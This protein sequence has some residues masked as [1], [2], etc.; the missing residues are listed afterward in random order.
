MRP[1][2]EDD[3]TPEEEVLAVALELASGSWKIAFQ[4]GKHAKPAVLT[5]SADQASVR[6]QEVERE[7]AKIRRK[8]HVSAGARTVVLYEAGQDGFWIQ[9]ALK[10]RGIKTLICDPG[11]I[12]MPRKQRRA[13][14]D[15]LAAIKLVSCLRG[16]LRGE[17]DRMHLIRVPEE[18]DEA[19]R[20]LSRERGELV[21]E[22]MQH[23]DRIRKLLR[24]LGGWYSV[25]GD[26]GNQLRQ[27]QIR[28]HDGTSLPVELRERLIRE[29]ERLELA[30]RQLRELEEELAHQLPEQTQDKIATLQKLKAVGQIG[31][32]R[33]VLE[34]FWRH[35]DNGKQVGA[36]IGLVPQPFDSGESRVDQGI[37]KQGNRKV[38]SLMIEMAWFWLRYQPESA[39]A[40]WYAART[41]GS[42]ASKRS[43]RSAIVA[44]ARRVAIALWRYLE[45]G[46]MPEGAAFK[47]A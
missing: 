4:D 44:V 6:L 25:R 36:C 2:C 33:L 15:R 22:C 47:A 23:R 24:T 38:R 12:P 14:T 27:G 9:R 31:A 32:T 17:H 28:C 13:K 21:K 35:F 34:L 19:Q 10:A 41:S 45:H 16:W 5:V 37:S 46:M 11:S 7:I 20:H 42:G 39:I 1:T 40:K 29:S 26:V 3:F 43:K 30:E 18:Q 8:W